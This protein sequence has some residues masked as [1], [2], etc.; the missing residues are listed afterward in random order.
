[1]NRRSGHRP[2]RPAVLER[3]G[4]VARPARAAGGRTEYAAAGRWGSEL[5]YAPTAPSPLR[6]VYR[7]GLGGTAGVARHPR[8]VAQVRGLAR[9][10]GVPLLR[11]PAA[12]RDD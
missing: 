4:F 3:I 7:D 2:V 8:T 9:L 11:E 6:W 12:G 5:V 10:L 1:M